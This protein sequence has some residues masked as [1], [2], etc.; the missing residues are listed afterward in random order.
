[1]NKI[2]NSFLSQTILNFTGV[3]LLDFHLSYYFGHVVLFEKFEKFVVHSK[4][5]TNLLLCLNRL[6]VKPVKRKHA[7]S[8]SSANS[9]PR[10]S[11]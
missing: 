6:N 7:C 10:T 5:L 3:L 4:G 8:I 2:E 1:M 11:S 9:K